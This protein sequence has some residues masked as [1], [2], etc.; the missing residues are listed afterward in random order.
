MDEGGILIMPFKFHETSIEGLTIIEPHIF[1][2]ERGYMIK[3]F[4]KNIFS[5]QGLPDFFIE[6]NESKSKK[7]TLRGLHFQQRYS[8]GKLI[9]VIKGKVFDVAVDLRF[10]SKTFGKWEGFELSDRNHNVLY[11]PKGFAHGYLALEEDSIFSYKCTDIYSPEYDSGIRFNDVDIG[12]KWPFNIVGKEN[13][14]IS[15]KDKK[16]MSFSEFVNKKEAIT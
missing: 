6:C 16:L 8:Q 3:D 14:I 1:E 10:N 5:E 9:R 12:I 15:E 11:I 4:E 2:D 13:I 7:G